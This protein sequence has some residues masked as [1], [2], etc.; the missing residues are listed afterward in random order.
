M[1]VI[2]YG[3]FQAASL[4]PPAAWLDLQLLAM[5]ASNSSASLSIL[6]FAMHGIALFM[7]SLSP[8]LIAL[9]NVS[10][11]SDLGY[12][13]TLISSGSGDC[14]MSLLAPSA[15]TAQQLQAVWLPTGFAQGR[16]AIVEASNHVAG[17]FFM[18]AQFKN[19]V[20]KIGGKFCH[21]TLAA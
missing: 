9:K 5:N 14:R 19:N 7:L 6:P 15:E 16:L 3:Q 10:P 8:N 4:L 1:L 18:T 21:F 13:G 20:T 2:N 11:F 17:V 12:F